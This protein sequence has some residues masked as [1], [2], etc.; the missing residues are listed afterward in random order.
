VDTFILVGVRFGVLGP[1]EAR[2]PDGGPVAVGGPQVR[3]LLAMLLLDAGRPVSADRL[4]EGLYGTEA[5]HALQSQVSRL[6]RGLKDIATVEFSPAGYR[7]AIDPETVDAHRFTQQAAQGK[8]LISGDPRKAQQLLSEALDLWRGPALA[9]VLDAPFAEAAAARLAEAKLTAIEDHAEATL[10]LNEH[11]AVAAELSE[12]VQAHPLRE[13][14]RAL[15]MRAL[16]AAG[17]QAEAL[18][19]YEQARQHLG[20][21]L[22]VDPSAELAEAHLDILRAVPAKTARGRSRPS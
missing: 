22:G 16:Y 11:H 1:V 9:D 20:E 21:E 15:L 3:A 17:R 12:I 8:A 6:R 19:V 13:R 2:L 4:V 10:A 14:A 7:L 5:A 18:A